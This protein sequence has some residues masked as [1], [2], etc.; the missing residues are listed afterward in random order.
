MENNEAYIVSADI[1]ASKIKVKKLT[2]TAK[3]P[4]KGSSKAAGYDLYADESAVIKPGET[5]L[6]STGLSMAL[7]EGTFGA[8]FARSGLAVKQGLRLAN[9][10]GVADEDF[11]GCYM[12][13]LHND[14]Q[15]AAPVEQGDRIAQLVILPYVA[16]NFIEVDEL[17][18]TDRGAGG[19]GS[20]GVK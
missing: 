3:T 13:A 6:I 16:A 20:T 10:V 15:D 7:P 17:D 14:S 1:N 9:G 18:D 11:R 2:D 8:I 4:T 5:R 19:F 12:V